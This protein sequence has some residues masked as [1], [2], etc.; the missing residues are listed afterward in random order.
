MVFSTFFLFIKHE[1]MFIF[2]FTEVDYH[3]NRIYFFNSFYIQCF[4]FKPKSF[5]IRDFDE[6]HYAIRIGSLVLH[7]IGQLLPHQLSIGNF[8]NRDYIYPVSF[9]LDYLVYNL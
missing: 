3:N 4:I 7:N 2:I 6:N 1:K 8:N 9:Y 5:M